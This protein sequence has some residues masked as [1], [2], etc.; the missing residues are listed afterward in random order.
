MINNHDFEVSAP[1]LCGMFLMGEPIPLGL[2]GTGGLQIKLQLAPSIEANFG[3]DAA[4]SYYEIENPSLTCALGVPVGGKLP[5]ISALPYLSYSSFYGVLNNGDE[6]H[7]I[8]CGLAS[9]LISC[10]QNILL[11][12]QKMVI[13]LMN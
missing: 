3:A 5:K 8:N 6:T 4:G 12:I 10:Q 11:I 1:L 2:N 7:N 13:Q 9:V